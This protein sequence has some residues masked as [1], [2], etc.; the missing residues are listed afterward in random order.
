MSN[1]VSFILF[2]CQTNRTDL[3]APWQTVHLHQLTLGIQNQLCE[4]E[5]LRRK[6]ALGQVGV[7]LGRVP[8]LLQS[9][10]KNE[11][12]GMSDEL[13]SNYKHTYNILIKLLFGVFFF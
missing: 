7:G 5:Q 12:V 3:V 8:Q 10:G 11:L 9:L 1:Y 6:R 2:M 13:F 4:G